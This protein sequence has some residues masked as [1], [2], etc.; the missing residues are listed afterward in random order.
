MEKRLP[1]ALRR[2]LKGENGLPDRARIGPLVRALERGDLRPEGIEVALDRLLAGEDAQ[3]ILDELRPCGDG[4]RELEELLGGAAAHAVERMAGKPP[5]KILRWAMG[6]VL[7]PLRGRVDPALVRARLIAGLKL[8]LE[9]VGADGG[10]IAPGDRRTKG[11]GV[12]ADG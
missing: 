3:R 7:R 5:D 10:S 12:R 6:Q 4:D 2:S 11:T 9:G 8:V 1:A